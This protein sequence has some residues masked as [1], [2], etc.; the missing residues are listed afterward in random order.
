MAWSLGLA[1][2]VQRAQRAEQRGPGSPWPPAPATGWVAV[3]VL[4]AP[5][6]MHLFH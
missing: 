1:G 6:L 2:E 4:Q 3:T 5:G